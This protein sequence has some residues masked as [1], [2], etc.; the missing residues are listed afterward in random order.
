VQDLSAVK[1]LPPP[2]LED[3][4]AR[5]VRRLS[6]AQKKEKDTTK[7]RRNRKIREHEALLKRHRQQR[8]EGLPEEESPSETASEEEDG[9]NN[10][11]DPGSRYDTATFLVH[12]PDVRSLQGPIGGGSTSQ[13]SRAASAL[14]EGKEER[15]KGRALERPLE[16]RSTE[17][18]VPSTSAAPRTRARSPHTSSAGGAATS[19]PEAGALSSGVRT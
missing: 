19:M 13:A 8:L 4:T 16:R 1:D 2:V 14:V 10:E 6:T 11:D 7:T 15:A 5:Q 18:G 3:R 12:L 9:Y 17:P